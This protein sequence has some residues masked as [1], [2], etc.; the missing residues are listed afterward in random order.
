MTFH[1]LQPTRRHLMA[2]WTL[3]LFLA[4][5]AGP[6][7]ASEVDFSGVWRYSV[8]G[9]VSELVIQNNGRFSKLDSSQTNKTMISGTVSVSQNPPVLRLNIQD[10]APKEFCGPLGCEPIRM[11]AAEVYRFQFQ[12]AA[13]LVLSD[14]NGSYAFQRAR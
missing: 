1:I 2:G 8:P 9:Y 12:D 3:G 10:W 5:A 11:I 13:T 7:A 4:I 6:A 14:S